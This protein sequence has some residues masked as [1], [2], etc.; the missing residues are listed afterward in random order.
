MGLWR[1]EWAVGAWV[2]FPCSTLV[3]GLCVGLRQDYPWEWK[4][5]W[6]SWS[7]QR[8]LHQAPQGNSVLKGTSVHPLNKEY[9]SKSKDTSDECSGLCHVFW[10]WVPPTGRKWGPLSHELD[11]ISCQSGWWE[12]RANWSWFRR[13]HCNISYVHGYRVTFKP[14]AP[15]MQTSC[16]FSSCTRRSN[17]LKFPG[18]FFSQLPCLLWPCGFYGK[19]HFFP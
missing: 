4:K 2:L 3:L 14:T 19:T 11:W 7:Q 5:K 10:A 15:A 17:K 12:L 16:A 9:N 1:T 8:S 18:P 13:T 6:A